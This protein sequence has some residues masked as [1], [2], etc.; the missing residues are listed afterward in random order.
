MS[1]IYL[2]PPNIPCIKCSMKIPIYEL[3]CTAYGDNLICPSCKEANPMS[4]YGKFLGKIEG[5]KDE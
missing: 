3:G 5:L 2:I 1:D 4:Y